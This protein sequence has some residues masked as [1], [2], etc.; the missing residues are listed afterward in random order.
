MHG[1]QPG[2]WILCST[3]FPSLFGNS[4]FLHSEARLSS[5]TQ[6]WNKSFSFHYC[7]PKGVTNF[8]CCILNPHTLNYHIAHSLSLSCNDKWDLFIICNDLLLFYWI[9]IVLFPF[10]LDCYCSL[11]YDQCVSH[12][13]SLLANN[14][15]AYFALFSSCIKVQPENI[16]HY[17]T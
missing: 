5:I 6:N 12:F 7:L 10:L 4:I 9:V 2:I 17:P 15:Y 14:A 8:Q 3:F 11:N 16:S 13:F 1:F